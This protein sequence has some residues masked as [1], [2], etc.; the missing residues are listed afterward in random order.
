[1][2]GVLADGTRS[3]H[4]GTTEDTES[5]EKG[6]DAWMQ[7]RGDDSSLVT[8]AARDTRLPLKKFRVRHK[9]SRETLPSSPSFSVPSV[10]S[11]VQDLDLAS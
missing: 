11:V 9:G 3:H 4:G 2:I 8:A 5:T 1:V 6:K 10:I 7:N